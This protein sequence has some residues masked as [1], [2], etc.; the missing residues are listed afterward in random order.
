MKE[1]EE[2]MKR[3]TL[4]YQEKDLPTLLKLEMEW[5]AAESHNLDK[6]SDDKLKLYISA[7]LEQ[8][9]ELEDERYSIRNHPRFQAIIDFSR[10]TE[11]VGVHQIMNQ[12]S[13]LKQQKIALESLLLTIS[14]PNS[15]KYIMDF[16]NQYVEDIEEDFDPW[17]FF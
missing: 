9:A 14:S 12:L 11:A 17:D 10:F 13:E 4:A 15:K 1:K 3:V 6:M 8:V 7:L 2:L 16:V 5:V